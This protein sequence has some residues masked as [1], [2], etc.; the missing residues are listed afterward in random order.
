MNLFDSA[1]EEQSLGPVIATLSYRGDH[2]IDGAYLDGGNSY[3]CDGG[4]TGNGCGD[5][6]GG[7]GASDIYGPT[8]AVTLSIAGDVYSRLA[9]YRLGVLR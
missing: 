9:A 1:F 6:G 7:G 2:G 8:C 3:N 4:G 5:F